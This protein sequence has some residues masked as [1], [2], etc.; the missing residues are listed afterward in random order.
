MNPLV[1]DTQCYGM[2]KSQ[3]L[4]TW[5]GLRMIISGAAHARTH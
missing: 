4:I 1:L 5:V 2:R 3:I